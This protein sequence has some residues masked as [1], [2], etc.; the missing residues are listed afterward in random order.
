[1]ASSP[2][3]PRNQTFRTFIIRQ[4]VCIRI[5][6][7]CVN[8]RLLLNDGSLENSVLVILKIIMLLLF[9]KQKVLLYLVGNNTYRSASGIFPTHCNQTQVQR[10]CER[11]LFEL[12]CGL[13]LSLQ[14]VTTTVSAPQ[15]RCEM[16]G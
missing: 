4:S 16:G 11:E 2:F 1:M 13:C 14:T 10:T 6:F 3:P 5:L 12:L 9:D 8:L 15:S 7:T